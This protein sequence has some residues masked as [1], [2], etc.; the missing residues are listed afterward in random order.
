M[1]SS[2]RRHGEDL[3]MTEDGL[4]EALAACEAGAVA[5][6]E[7]NNDTRASAPIISAP[8]RLHKLLR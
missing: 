3:G 8:I 1:E 2:L 5:A 7:S 4:C 6:V